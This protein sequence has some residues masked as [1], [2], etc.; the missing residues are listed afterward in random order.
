MTKLYQIVVPK[1]QKA[2]HLQ[3]LALLRIK[4]LE[5]DVI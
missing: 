1:L 4:F 3:I 5:M 2:I